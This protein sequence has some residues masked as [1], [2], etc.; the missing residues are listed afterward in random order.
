VTIFYCLRFETSLF[1][2]SYPFYCPHT[3]HTE[4]TISYSSFTVSVHI[5]CCGDMFTYLFYFYCS[6]WKRVK[7]YV[8]ADGQLASL[9]W[10]KAPIWGLQQHNLCV[11]VAAGPCL[12]I[13]Y[14]VL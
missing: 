11:Y 10:N 14:C 4:V 7:S 5:R 13:L 3:N 1:I 12:P 8:M 2:A 6:V 9:S